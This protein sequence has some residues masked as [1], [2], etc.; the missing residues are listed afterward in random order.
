[1]NKRFVRKVVSL[2]PYLS[3]L[4][5]NYF[6]F[7]P[8]DHV[9][10]GFAI[11]RPPSGVYVWK[12]A[13]PLYDRYVGMHL[14]Y[15]DRLPYPDDYIDVRRCGNDSLAQEFVRRI[16]QYRIDAMSLCQLS[17][18]AIYV[19]NTIGLQNYEIRRGYALTLI[20]LDRIDD[21]VRELQDLCRSGQVEYDIDFCREIRSLRDGLLGDPCRVKETLDAWER[22]TRRNIGV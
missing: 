2:A 14:N 20:M 19:K 10:C 11:E 16:E 6:H 17:R 3:P 13:L 8:V 4:G 21:A 9:L 18:F 5:K 12:F 22:D 15:S 7:S 1:M